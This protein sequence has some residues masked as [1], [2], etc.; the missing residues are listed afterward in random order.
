MTK[1]AVVAQLVEHLHGKE[2]VAGSTPANGFII[3]RYCQIWLGSVHYFY[4]KRT[5][6]SY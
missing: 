1:Y 4:G 5:T 2:K 6:Q 3:P